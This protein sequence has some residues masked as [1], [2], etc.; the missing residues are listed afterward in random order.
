MA[1]DLELGED[2]P[3]LFM[4]TTEDRTYTAS[5]PDGAKK[6]IWKMPYGEVKNRIKESMWQGNIV[7][8][9]LADKSLDLAECFNWSRKWRSA[10]TYAICIQSTRS[11]S[12]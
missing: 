7:S 11:C 9:R 12:S 3:T 6:V 8:H 2:E 10:P 4:K 5:D 1:L